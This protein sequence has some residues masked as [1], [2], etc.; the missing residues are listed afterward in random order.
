MGVESRVSRFVELTEY[1]L[2]NVLCY[3]TGLYQ[4]KERLAKAFANFGRAIQLRIHA[5]GRMCRRIDRQMANTRASLHKCLVFSF[6]A[7]KRPSHHEISSYSTHIQIIDSVSGRC[8]FSRYTHFLTPLRLQ[9][10]PPRCSHQ[11]ANHPPLGRSHQNSIEET[12]VF[13]TSI[14]LSTKNLVIVVVNRLIREMTAED[15]RGVEEC[16]CHA[17]T[18]TR[19]ACSS[20]SIR[21]CSGTTM[22]CVFLVRRMRSMI[23]DDDNKIVNRLLGQKELSK[24]N[25]DNIEA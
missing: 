24:Q 16:S 4:I 6:P 1:L 10:S 18:H 20:Q 5:D 8:S 23:V 12:I 2:R 15:K 22:H 9:S 19:I 17:R 25:R 14:E 11:T 13:H 3:L 7:V 21:T